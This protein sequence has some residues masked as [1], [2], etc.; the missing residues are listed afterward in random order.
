MF[1]RRSSQLDRMGRTKGLTKPRTRLPDRVSF[2]VNRSWSLR[3]QVQRIQQVTSHLRIIQLWVLQC[4]L[5]FRLKSGPGL[6]G[7]ANVMGFVFP[8][9]CKQLLARVSK[10]G[11]PVTRNPFSL[12]RPWS[13]D[14]EK[15]AIR[16]HVYSIIRRPTNWLNLYL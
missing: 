16:C 9:E 5:L 15:P 1:V 7:G 14:V 2:S 6:S 13:L 12:P 3:P 10:A 11:L 4:T 8:L